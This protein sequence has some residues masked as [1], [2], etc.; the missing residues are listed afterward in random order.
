MTWPYIIGYLLA[1][2]TGGGLGWGV[3]RGATITGLQAAV[4]ARDIQ[5]KDLEKRV[6]ELEAQVHRLIDKGIDAEAETQRLR[7]RLSAALAEHTAAE[8]DRRELEMRWVQCRNV[9][10]C[11]LNRQPIA[12]EG[13]HA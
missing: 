8:A 13:S 4:E 6:N 2:F 3:H 9:P 10:G 11:P 12:P 5:I 1:L 7:E